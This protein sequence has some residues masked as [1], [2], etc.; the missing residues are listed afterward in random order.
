AKW[1]RPKS[2][3]A[4][5]DHRH[6][7]LVSRADESSRFRISFGPNERHEPSS[8]WI[9]FEERTAYGVNPISNESSAGGVNHF[10][11][12]TMKSPTE[13]CPRSRA[14]NILRCDHAPAP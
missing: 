2:P 13:E 10:A 12:S 8:T 7:R 5:S 11:R 9:V 6:I 3:L 14:L 4:R 1:F